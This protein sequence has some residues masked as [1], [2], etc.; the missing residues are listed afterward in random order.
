MLDLATPYISLHR[1]PLHLQVGIQVVPCVPTVLPKENWFLCGAELL[2]LIAQLIDLSRTNE[3]IN[4]H[5]EIWDYMVRHSI[6]QGQKF[7]GQ[8]LAGMR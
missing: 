3:L 7:R 4:F 8:K 1:I 6:N 2:G 5:S